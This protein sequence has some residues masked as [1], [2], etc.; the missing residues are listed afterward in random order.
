VN[1]LELVNF[2]SGKDRYTHL[3]HPY[4]AKLLLNIPYFFL[5]CRSVIK[6]KG[7][8]L[9]PFC[10]SGTVPLESI[11]AGHNAIGSDANPLARMITKAK[12]TPLN[13][14]DLESA[15]TK[16]ADTL[17][18]KHRSTYTP[19]AVLD[20]NYWYNKRTQRQLKLIAAAIS[21]ITDTK[22]NNFLNMCFSNC[23]KKSSYADKNVSVPVKINPE[24]YIGDNRKYKET[25]SRIT[26]IKKT[27]VTELFFG[28]VANNT[29]R[30]S[31]FDTAQNIGEVRSILQDARSLEGVDDSSV[32][33]IIT[34]P[35]YA[36]AQKYIRSSS[37]SLGWL[38]LC[39]DNRLRALEE[40]NIGRE[41]YKKN[42]YTICPNVQLE[43]AQSTI[44]KIW[45]KNPLRAHIAGNYLI[46]MRAA[47]KECYRVL[48]KGHSFVLVVGNNEVCGHSFETQKYLS[49]IC[50]QAG[51]TVEAVL[52]DEI[53]S[54]GLMTKRNKTASIITC[55]WIIVLRKGK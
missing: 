35:P 41:H 12:T 31:R 23:V 20:W 48:K 10:G 39:P 34:S 38:K 14:R 13:K 21:E 25:T 49:D 40:N 8:V 50:E 9:D 7:I 44:E 27:D 53:K 29:K 17:Q 28:I 43:S 54:R 51:F 26:K 2:H 37:L 36:G 6:T 15:I 18:Q 1:F 32:D 22:I 19:Q 5:R 11:V 3:C 4:P 55:E 24:R 47:I 30:L 52:K 45:S 42:E 16:I 33:L 46:E